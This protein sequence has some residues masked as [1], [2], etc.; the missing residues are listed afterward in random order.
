MENYSV[1]MSVYYKETATNLRQSIDS[2]LCQTVK[3]NQFLIICD[4]PLS[5]ELD[6][7]LLEYEKNNCIELYRLEKNGG[8]GEALKI[9]IGL[10]RNDFILR[11]DSDD[12]SVPSRAEKEISLLKIYDIVGSNIVEFENEITNTIG[13]RRVPETQ[14]QIIK[15]SKKRSPFNHPSVAF[16]KSAVL[17]SGNYEHFLYLED[18]YLWIRMIQHGAKCFNIQAPLVFMRSGLTMRSRRGGKEYLKSLKKLRKYMLQTKYI[19]FF[20]FILYSCLSGIL[21]RLPI[22]LKEKVYTHFLRK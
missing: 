14:K 13:M 22:K 7:V 5:K 3:P 16:R 11:M 12:Y 6:D 4:G 18:Y 17:A 21:L 19:N 1:L 15:F 9:G 8:L 10:C 20:Q 2:M